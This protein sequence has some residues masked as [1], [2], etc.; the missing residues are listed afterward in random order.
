VKLKEETFTFSEE[1]LELTDWD[2]AEEYDSVEDMRSDLESEFQENNIMLMLD[3]IND[4]ARAQGNKQ[5]AAQADAWQG[6]NPSMEV[7]NQLLKP[8][9]FGWYGN[10]MIVLRNTT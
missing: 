6:K 8:L 10:K 7:L 9:G 5:I 3:T 1:D 2:P 4:V